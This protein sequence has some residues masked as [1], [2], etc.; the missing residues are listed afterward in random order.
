MAAEPERRAMVWVGPPLLASDP[1]FGSA[2]IPGHEAS[3]QLKFPPPSLIVVLQFSPLL[4]ATRLFV[5][6]IRPLLPSPPPPPAWFPAMVLS[7]I[8][9]VAALEIP[10]PN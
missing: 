1:S 10:P 3:G 8:N 6:V 7:V 2:L 9:I 5:M 4:L